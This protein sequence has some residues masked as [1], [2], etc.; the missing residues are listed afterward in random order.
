VLLCGIAATSI[1][2]QTSTRVV[3]VAPAFTG[4]M[5]RYDVQTRSALFGTGTSS[6]GTFFY[7]RTGDGTGRGSA[8]LLDVNPTPAMRT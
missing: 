4:T 7:S 2:S 5:A 1:V 3:A 8:A 6:A